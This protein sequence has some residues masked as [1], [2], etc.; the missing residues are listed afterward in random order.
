MPLRLLTLLLALF[1][2]LAWQN[3]A[4][5]TGV[6]IAIFPLQDLSH[7]DDG[8]NWPLTEQLHND[9]TEKGLEVVS[10]QAVV[11]FMVRHRIRVLGQL[12]NYH[13]RTAKKELGVKLILIGSICQQKEK[14]GPA[15]ALVLYLLRTEDGKTTWANTADLCCADTRR[16]LGIN[17]PKSI[18]D[19]YPL[20]SH[21]ILSLWP[22][23]LSMQAKHQRSVD[24]ESAWLRPIYLR[25]GQDTLCSVKLRT[26]WSPN[27]QP[28][29][30]L[31]IGEQLIP[32]TESTGTDYYEFSWRA[33][34]PDGRYPV[35]LNTSWPDGHKQSLL[36]GSYFI[37]N[38]PPDLSLKLRGL[39]IGDKITFRNRLA[40]I[41]KMTS[42]EPLS[43]WQITFENTDGETLLDQDGEGIPPERLFWQG[44]ASNRKPFPDGDYLITMRVWDRAGNSAQAKEWV[45]VL[46]AK[47]KLSINASLTE[48]E[49]LI[50]LSQTGTTPISFWRIDLRDKNGIPMG[51]KDGDTLPTKIHLPLAS[52]DR[53]R[54]IQGSILVQDILGNQTRMQIKDLLSLAK[55][56]EDKKEKKQTPNKAW[57][58]EF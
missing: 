36:L 18:E 9:L 20:L 21:N 17:E 8:V 33:K 44:K 52:K 19:L 26:T 43:R 39:L 48:K 11:S 27:N 22:S 45:T 24:I 54:Q 34:G 16:L 58:D 23:N 25:S 3:S 50:D 5:A 13:I 2:A 42:R 28:E 30:L 32:V 56:K 12:E 1:C 46:R 53:N 47:P 6:K 49:L 4:E 31:R 40:I 15:L 51:T 35:S 41:P 14:P 38:K 57:V 37:D 10:R 7:G 55:P 29:I